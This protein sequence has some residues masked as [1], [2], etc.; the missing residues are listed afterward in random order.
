[1]TRYLLIFFNKTD[2]FNLKNVYSLGPW[3]TPLCIMT[4]SMLMYTFYVYIAYQVSRFLRLY[5]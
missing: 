2:G 5:L 3:T 4:T 1:M